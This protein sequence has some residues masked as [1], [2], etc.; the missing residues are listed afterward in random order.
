MDDYNLETKVQNKRDK[1]LPK[2]HENPLK[3]T[4]IAPK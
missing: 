1:I 2:K 3:N 4:K